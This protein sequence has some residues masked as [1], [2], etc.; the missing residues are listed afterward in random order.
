MIQSLNTLRALAAYIVVIT[1][2]SKSTGLFNGFV[3]R[4]S[5]QMGVMLFFMISGFLMAYLYLDDK[6]TFAWQN[7]KNY[8]ISR[9]SRVLP[10]YLILVSCSFIL[11]QINDSV[12]LYNIPDTSS[13][14]S[15]LLLLEGVSVFWTIPPEIHFYVFFILLW[16]FYSTNKSIMILVLIASFILVSYLG[17]PRYSGNL[18]KLGYDFAFLRSL[19]YFLTGIVLGLL[20][21]HFQFS[22]D[23]QN[24]AYLITLI[25]LPLL[26]PDVFEFIFGYR[27]GLWQ[28]MH[29]LLMM[30]IVFVCF[31]FLT[32]KNHWFVANPIGDFLGKISYSVYLLHM[33]VLK[34]FKELGKN[35]PELYLFFFIA[36]TIVIAYFSY[37]LIEKPFRNYLNN[38]YKKHGCTN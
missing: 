26:F 36:C 7:V 21:R 38:K 20:Y 16:L 24:G 30:T 8:L 13:L 33:P 17:F 3:G 22:K 6:K 27:H 19:P 25:I 1:H 34:H 10:L 18:G 9:A 14:L 31:V 11:M 29:V 23:I 28:D 12:V 5:G 35:N 4:G 37:L 2:Y 15:H 32:P